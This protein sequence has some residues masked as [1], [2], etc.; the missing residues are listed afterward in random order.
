MS[1]FRIE[2]HGRLQEWVAEEKG[3]FKDEGLDYEFVNSY[4]AGE[5]GYA[6]VQSTETA[7]PEVKR[8]AFENMERGRAADISCACHWAVNMASSAGHGRMWGHA[9]SVTPSAIVVAPEAVIKKPRDLAKV[10]VGVGYHSGSYFSAIQAM[11]KVLKPDELKLRY[12]GQPRDRLA[13]ILD[14]KIVAVNLFGAPLY[15]A[16]QQ[17]FRKILDTTFMIGF[18][19]QKDAEVEDVKRY[20]NALQRAQRD[21]DLEPERYKHYFLK[22]L[23][24]KYHGMIDV[25][26]FGPGERLVFEPYTR[27]MFERT[28]RW[29]EETKLFPEGKTLTADYGLAVTV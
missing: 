6:V 23:P 5:S 2:P 1:K 26:G 13:A 14:R 19:M 11:E 3:Y 10:E 28:Y 15:L 29:M 22:E 24:E 7:A 8:G 27:E 12:I 17:G 9:Y 20:F 18:L 4:V 25:N 21:I 16:E